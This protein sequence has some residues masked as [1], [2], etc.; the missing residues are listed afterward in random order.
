MAA[1]GRAAVVTVSDSVAAGEREDVSGARVRELLEDQGWLIASAEVIPDDFSL[2]RE[3]LEALALNRDLDAVFTTGGTGLGARDRTPEATTSVMERSLPG[4]AEAMR[5]EGARKT[6]R[7]ALSR[8]VAGVKGGTLLINLPGSPEGAEDSL[9]AIVGILPHA[10][11]VLRG[12]ESHGPG[13]ASAASSPEPAPEPVSEH[14]SG[15]DS[16]EDA[17]AGEPA[18][19]EEPAVA[20]NAEQDVKQDAEPVSDHDSEP[21]GN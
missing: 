5:L 6:P 8:A 1:P 18:S 19:E 17:S 10:V 2:I 3:R 14:P 7:A 20:D 12:K 13:A 15:E 21:T 9:R 11:E 16:P 4:L